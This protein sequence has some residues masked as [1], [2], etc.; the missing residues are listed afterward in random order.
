MKREYSKHGDVLVFK[1]HVPGFSQAE[2]DALV[3]EVIVQGE[4]NDDHPEA[5]VIEQSVEELDVDAERRAFA[6]EEDETE[7]FDRD[8]PDDDRSPDSNYPADDDRI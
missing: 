5:R 8:D 3:G 4:S 2:I 6:D 1:F 7:T